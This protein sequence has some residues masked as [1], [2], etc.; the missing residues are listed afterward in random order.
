MYDRANIRLNVSPKMATG[1]TTSDLADACSLAYQMGYRRLH[2][3]LGAYSAVAESGSGIGRPRS[4]AGKHK[5]PTARNR[6]SPFALSLEPWLPSLQNVASSLDR[7]PLNL[8]PVIHNY[9]RSPQ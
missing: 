9:P 3:I 2:D 6:R 5:A 4:C 7:R 1:D 8:F